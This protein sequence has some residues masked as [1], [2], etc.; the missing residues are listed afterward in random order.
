MRHPGFG[1]LKLIRKLHSALFNTDVLP[2]SEGVDFKL[3][4]QEVRQCWRTS[5]SHQ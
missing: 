2:V 1:W 5:R 4:R 3:G